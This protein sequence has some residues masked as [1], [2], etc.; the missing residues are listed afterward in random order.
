MVEQ[1]EDDEIDEKLFKGLQ[2]FWVIV[3]LGEEESIPDP[4]WS[5]QVLKLLLSA[6]FPLQR[7][8]KNTHK[9]I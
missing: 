3:E 5:I 1:L 8:L 9:K 4:S 2:S 7:P 6:G